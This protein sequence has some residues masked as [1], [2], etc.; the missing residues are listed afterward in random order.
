MNLRVARFPLFRSS[1]PKG[2][3]PY[4]QSALGEPPRNN[5]IVDGQRQQSPPLRTQSLLAE[6][7]NESVVTSSCGAGLYTAARFPGSSLEA[8]A[9]FEEDA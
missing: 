4:R 9:L 6:K 1:G 2:G 7:L 8:D 5:K 3:W